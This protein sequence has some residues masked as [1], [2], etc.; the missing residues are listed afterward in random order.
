MGAGYGMTMSRPTVAEGPGE[1][2]EPVR[3]P[4]R[5][6]FPDT[7]GI[8]PEAHLVFLSAAGGW[9]DPVITELV[10]SGLAWPRVLAYARSERAVPTILRRLEALGATDALPAEVLATLRKM[11]NVE[12]FGMV[13][14]E[15]RVRLLLDRLGTDGLDVVLLKGAAIALDRLGGLEKRPMGDVDLL[16]RPGEADRV[17]AVALDQGW[18]PVGRGLEEWMYEDMHHLQPLEAPDG[19]GFGLEVHTDLFP[20]WG[21]FGFSARDI[22]R[23]AVPTGEWRA[24]AGI[25]VPSVQHQLLHTCLHFAWS[26]CFSRGSWRM[27][28]DLD[29]LLEDPDFDP[30]ALAE[31]ARKTGGASCVW[32][33]LTLLQVLTGRSLPDGLLEG[34][35]S[36]VPRTGRRIVL[37]HLVRESLRLPAPAGTLRLRKFLW[38]RAVAPGRNG[39]GAG[40]PWASGGRWPDPDDPL[41]TAGPRTDPWH[42][43][44]GGMLRYISSIATTG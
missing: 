38:T 12:E 16:A 20:A 19:L 7:R 33:T 28:R 2:L 41:G 6:A 23:D 15:D 24:T 36:F 25:R 4:E 32:W 17:Q 10:A 18:K 29:L 42:V 5:R 35:E 37:R 21:P 13:V 11:A 14:L 40:R 39:H 1:R 43:R 8:V 34:L 44:A 22:W 30:A 27:V 3:R 31:L 26:H 9:A